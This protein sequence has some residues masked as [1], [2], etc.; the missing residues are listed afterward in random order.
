MTSKFAQEL[1]EKC[2]EQHADVIH[3]EGDNG[4][5]V[6]SVGIR[7]VHCA[8]SAALDFVRAHIASLIESGYK[9]G[10]EA[11]KDGASEREAMVRTINQ[12]ECCNE[13]REALGVGLD[14]GWE[15]CLSVIR[16]MVATAK[17]IPGLVPPTD[18]VIEAAR[19]EGRWQGWKKGKAAGWEEAAKVDKDALKETIE[20]VKTHEREEEHFLKYISHAT[21][22]KRQALAHAQALKEAL[23]K[24]EEAAPKAGELQGHSVQDLLAHVLLEAPPREQAPPSDGEGSARSLPKA[25]AQEG[26]AARCRRYPR[27]AIILGHHVLEAPP[28][29]IRRLARLRAALP[30]RRRGPQARPGARARNLR[31]S[32]DGRHLQRGGTGGRHAVG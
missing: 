30:R 8:N 29:R 2:V 18:E 17:S 25:P 13:L 27:R 19:E 21:E 32:G 16:H 5:A 3:F 15:Q 11:G 31:G 6:F 28:G 4:V 14:H 22:N 23:A 7:A 10:V 1:A 26:Q 12:T 9:A 20:K 24:V